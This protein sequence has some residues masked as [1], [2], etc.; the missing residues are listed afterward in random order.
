MPHASYWQTSK[1]IGAKV[2]RKRCQPTGISRRVFFGSAVGIVGGELWKCQAHLSCCLAWVPSAEAVAIAAIPFCRI[3][4]TGNG[5]SGSWSSGA[6]KLSV[7]T[8]AFSAARPGF[9]GWIWSWSL[10]VLGKCSC[11]F[12]PPVIIPFAEKCR[13]EVR[14]KGFWK[15]FH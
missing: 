2:S 5:H 6:L 13:R 8:A 9:R 7:V 14:W 11:S 4:H 12:E 10:R 1:H 15:P 3:N